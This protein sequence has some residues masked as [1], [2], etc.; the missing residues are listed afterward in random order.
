MFTTK[1]YNPKNYT[2]SKLIGIFI[3]YVAERATV[4]ER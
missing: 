4:H 2:S 3:K 1:K